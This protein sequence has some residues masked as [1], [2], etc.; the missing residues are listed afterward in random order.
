MDFAHRVGVIDKPVRC[1]DYCFQLFP[2]LSSRSAV[3]KSIKRGEVLLNGHPATTG[4]W[5]KEGDLIEFKRTSSQSHIY[6]QKLTV[7]YEDDYLAVIVKPSDVAMTSRSGRSLIHM[8]AYNL[9]P[10]TQLDALRVF[11]PIH[12]L[13]RLTYGMVVI[14]K[15]QASILA[16][17]R[18]MEDRKIIKKYTAITAGPLLN[19]ETVTVDDPVENKD[20]ISHFY[21]IKRW[22]YKQLGFLSLWSIQIETGRTH[23]IRKHFLSLGHGILGDPLYGKKEWNVLKRGLHLMASE[24]KFIHPITQH[25]L[26]FKLPY[27]KK[28]NRLIFP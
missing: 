6:P 21:L 19:F 14:A 16:L 10:S 25:E 17:S 28:F 20:A 11:S 27:T 23:Q 22:N 3:K 24:L 26:H 9:Q 2:S 7:L 18:A 5:L 8:L 1:S 4:K 13:D 12:R 15:T